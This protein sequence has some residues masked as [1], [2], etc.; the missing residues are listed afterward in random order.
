MKTRTSERETRTDRALSFRVSHFAILIS[1]F[2]LAGCAS[3]DKASPTTQP[4]SVRDRQDQALKDPM[5]YR[6]NVGKK[7][8]SK[9]GTWDFD[10]EGFKRD[11]DHVFNP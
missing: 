5:N 1:S 2:F 10:R 7:D 4:S 6:V 9:D 11:M 3:D 8:A